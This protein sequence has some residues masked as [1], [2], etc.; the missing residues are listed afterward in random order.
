MIV[1]V[2]FRFNWRSVA[3]WSEEIFLT[4]VS[5]FSQPAINPFVQNYKA[6]RCAFLNSHSLLLDA[7][8]NDVEDPTTTITIGL[9]A[10]GVTGT[11]GPLPA[12]LTGDDPVFACARVKVNA[13][14]GKPR[15]Y[16]FRG[17]ADG[18]VEDGYI[19]WRYTGAAAFNDFVAGLVQGTAGIQRAVFDPSVN[20]VNNLTAI[21]DTFAVEGLPDDIGV[22]DLV[23]IQTQVV[24][25]GPKI[26]YTGRVTSFTDVPSSSTDLVQVTGWRHG[27]CS[28]GKLSLYEYL[29]PNQA[30]YALYSPNYCSYKK[31]G[32]AFTPFRG[33]A[34]PRA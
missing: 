22:G 23:R 4:T 31:T 26:Y 3:G 18:D 8:C 2:V 13:P 27:L 17:L 14:G 24:G 30:S 25:N 11:G 33:R 9:N 15:V 16:H 32:R 19:T 1:R 10:P 21:P 20:V 7:V 5:S 6:L 34:S 12:S 28:G 29:Y